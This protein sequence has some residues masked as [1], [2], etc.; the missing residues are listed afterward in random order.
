MS[1]AGASRN[2]CVALCL[3]LTMQ[4]LGLL[5]C[6]VSRTELKEHTRFPMLVPSP[7]ASYNTSYTREYLLEAAATPL[8]PDLTY[9]AFIPAPT[10]CR[11]RLLASKRLLGG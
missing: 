5:L 3:S 11:S 8:P 7:T 6:R 2:S 10:T 4:V 9:P 1:N